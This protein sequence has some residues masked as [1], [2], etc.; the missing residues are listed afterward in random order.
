MVTKL[1][2]M[3]DM[4][5]VIHIENK[6]D[7]P[8]RAVVVANHPYLSPK[9]WVA[10]EEIASH[11]SHWGKNEYN[12]R[13]IHLS[14]IRTRI[15]EALLGDS[16]DWGIVIKPIGFRVLHEEKLRCLHLPERN[17]LAFLQES[18]KYLN[19]IIIFPEGGVRT[20]RIHSGFAVAAL[21]HR[22]PIVYVQLPPV[23]SLFGG[24]HLRGCVVKYIHYPQNEDSVERLI[25]IFR[26][27]IYIS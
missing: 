4:N 24:D 20:G 18:L 9:D 14:I 26:K 6:Q 2:A 13:L 23:I 5:H 15:F 8:H 17:R 19:K 7:I 27:K 22:L 25:K 3:L 16:Q 10:A 12:H 11:C 1:Q 21:E